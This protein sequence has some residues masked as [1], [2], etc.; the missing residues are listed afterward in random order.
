MEQTIKQP[1]IKKPVVI[2]VRVSAETATA[3]RQKIKYTTDLRTLIENYSNEI[4]KS[5][6]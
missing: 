2:S 5:V 4:H 3:L 1:K 6:N